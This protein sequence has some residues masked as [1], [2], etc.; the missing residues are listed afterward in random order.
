MINGLQPQMA[1]NVCQT[2]DI[3]INGM[4]G[5]YTLVTID[6]MPIVSGLSS[7]YG[8]IGIP[9]SLIERVEVV[10]GPSSTLYGSEA[11]GGLIN[12]ITKNPA[13]AP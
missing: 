3:H 12:I 9:S 7:V 8:Q 2:A 1:C 5:A 13:T 6:G 4:E 11:V 10:K